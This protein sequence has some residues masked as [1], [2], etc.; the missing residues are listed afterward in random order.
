M[1][2]T[3]LN[4]TRK[5]GLS[6]LIRNASLLL[7][8]AGLLFL[9]APRAQADDEQQD[10]PTRVARISYIDGT[11]SMQ[12]GGEGDWGSAAKNRPVTIGDKLW[13]DKDSRAE[14]QAGQV[15]IHLGSMT[16]L[17]FLNLDAGVTQMRLAEGSVNFRVRALQQG[18]L[19][20]LDT[21]NLAFTVKQAGDFRVDVSENGDATRITVIVSGSRWRASGIHRY[22]QYPVQL[23]GCPGTRRLGP[24]GLG[25]RCQGRQFRFREIRFA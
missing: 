17:S 24:V 2:K 15:A 8:M 4:G 14:L 25:T 7:S 23:S 21:P 18:E 22:R 19:S 6:A 5:F 13:V 12:P 11:V 10:P 3:T 16:A 1:N 20:E 9:V